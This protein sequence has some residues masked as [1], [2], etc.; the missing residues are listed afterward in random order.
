[1][2]NLKRYL[3]NHFIRAVSVLTA[4]TAA[5]QVITILALPLLTRIYTPDDFGMLAVFAALLSVLSVVAC[6]RYEVAIPTAKKKEDGFGLLVLALICCFVFSLLVGFGIIFFSGDLAGL[7]KR[8]GLDSLLWLLPIGV[9]LGGSYNALQ[10]WATREKAFRLIARTRLEQSVSS[11]GVQFLMGFIGFGAVGL[12]VGQIINSGAGLFGLLR[13]TV[14]NGEKIGSINAVR[15]SAIARDY[16]KYPK[17][18]MMEALT[19]TAAIHLPIL[20]IAVVT[21]GSELGFLMLA[22]RVMQAPMSLIGNSISQVYFANALVEYQN[23]NLSVFTK[24]IVKN[25]VKVGVGPLLV[26]G[27]ISPYLFVYIFGEEWGRAGILVA[28]MTPWFIL[29]FVASPISTALHVTGHQKAAMYTQIVSL[30]LRLLFVMFGYFIFSGLYIIE[31]YAVSGLAAY[32]CYLAVICSKA[33]I[34]LKSLF[35]AFWAGKIHVLIWLSIGILFVL[36]F[37]TLNLVYL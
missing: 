5:A 22:M 9:V 18:S 24:N 25:L 19:N 29:Q 28:W 32:T 6:L 31:F 34:P 16:I 13:R 36:L 12:V 11:V 26:A 23:N 2:L 27:I 33:K 15:L 8:P 7:L 21:T 20:V 37:E 10:F 35:Q 1:M 30:I 4:G 3:N 17:Y 14:F